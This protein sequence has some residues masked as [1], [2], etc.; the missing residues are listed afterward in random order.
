MHVEAIE[1]KMSRAPLTENEHVPSLGGLSV[2]LLGDQGAGLQ[3]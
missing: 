2:D 1:P 3:G